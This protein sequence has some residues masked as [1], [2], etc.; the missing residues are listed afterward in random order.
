[1][2]RQ[3]GYVFRAGEFWWLRYFESR[4]EDGKVV[5]RQHAKKLTKVLPEHRRLKRPP[6][7][8]EQLQVEFL[9]K[10]NP[11]ARRGSR[12]SSFW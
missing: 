2:S 12:R 5:R 4:V 1:M 6:E 8:V 11:F 3:K 10:V 7:Y 9:A